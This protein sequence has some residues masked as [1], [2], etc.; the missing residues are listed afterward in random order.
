M[1]GIEFRE[2]CKAHECTL[3]V[4]DSFNSQ[5]ASLK[6]TSKY[7]Y[8]YISLPIDDERELPDSYI[9]RECDNLYIPCPD[10][11]LVKNRTPK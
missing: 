11:A 2:W 5:N 1:T 3:E 10:K 4:K 9:E 8:I 6:I 7:G